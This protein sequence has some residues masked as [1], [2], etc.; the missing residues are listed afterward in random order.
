MATEILFV[1]HAQG[2]HN[3]CADLYGESA[4]NEEKNRDAELT[5]KG[6]QQTSYYGI[7]EKFDV[8]FCSPLRRCRSTLL[9]IY[10]ESNNMKVILDDR[11]VEQPCGHNLC[12]RRL[13]K[14]EIVESF[15]KAWDHANVNEIY[16]WEKD[17]QVDKAKIRAFTEEILKDHKGKKILVVSHGTWINN[18]FR[19]FKNDPYKWLDNCRSTRVTI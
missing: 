5:E 9:G 18:W 6:I 8:I 7:E 3:A 1:R 12:D 14:A 13:D 19:L 10:P 17:D 4:Y 16:T 2:T 11:L 15:P